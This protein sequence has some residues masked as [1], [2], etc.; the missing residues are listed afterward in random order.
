MQCEYP[1]HDHN[2][3][4]ERKANESYEIKISAAVNSIGRRRTG[5]I[6]EII[7]DYCTELT[8]T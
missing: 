1:S 2:D 8:L 4:Y 6:E 7:P 3:T 5:F